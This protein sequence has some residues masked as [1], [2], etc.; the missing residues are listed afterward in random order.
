MKNSKAEVYVS[1]MYEAINR[2]KETP[3]FEGALDALFG[4]RGWRKG[5]SIPDSEV[6]KDYFYGLYEAQLRAAGAKHVVRFELHSGNRLVYAIFFGTQ[7]WKGADRMKEA[8]WKVAPFGD[9]TFKGS[10]TGQLTLGMKGFQPTALRQVLRERF[11]GK[12]FVS[13]DAVEEFVGSDQTDFHTR[14]L[15]TPVLIPMEKEGLVEVQAGTRKGSRGF[16]KGTRLRF[17]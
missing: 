3:E 15:K 10:R 1:F 4:T 9:F 11:H 12:G 7:H 8:I 17:L 13:I 2:F 16:P 5:I 6:R 14:Q